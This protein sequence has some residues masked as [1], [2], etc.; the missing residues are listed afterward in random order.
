MT[1][2]L[3]GEAGTAQSLV[4]GFN[5][6]KPSLKSP[7]HGHSRKV[8][9]ENASPGYTN[10]PFLRAPSA[11]P[12]S[13]SSWC[14]GSE[15]ITPSFFRSGRDTSDSFT[16]CCHRVCIKGVFNF[17]VSGPQRA[18]YTLMQLKRRKIG[19]RI[20]AFSHLLTFRFGV[21]SHQHQ[22]GAAP[23]CLHHTFSAILSASSMAE[24]YFCVS[25]GMLVL[26]LL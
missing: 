5:A 3:R 25:L 12:S 1:T 20:W 23:F 11:S 18:L 16:L 26:I 10:P 2:G 19:E 17:Q 6:F 13:A 7:L 22:W 15:I 4:K 9:L 8:S 14:P 21:M 24:S